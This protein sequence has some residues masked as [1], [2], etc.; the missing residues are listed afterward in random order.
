MAGNEPKVRVRMYRQGLGDC[1]LLTFRTGA[2]P[3]HMLV[4]CGTLGATT[5][6]V[7]MGDV[8]TNIAKETGEHLHLLIATHEHKDHVSGFRS[9]SKKFD[10]F[11]IDH[12]WAAW[13]ENP[14]DPLAQ[15][16]KVFGKDLESSLCL[17]SEVLRRSR[18]PVDEELRCIGSGVR[19]LLGFRG[20]LPGDE[21]ML[22]ADFA[23]TVQEAMNYVTKR[24]EGPDWFLSPGRVIEPPW[25]PGV[26]FYVLGP[27]RSKESLLKL[28]D[29]DSPELYHLA[30]Q[31]KRDMDR[32]LR[33][34]ASDQPLP[35]YRPTLDVPAREE[36]DASLPFDWGFRI[37]QDD[38]GAR[39]RYLAAYDD[40]EADWRRIDHEWLRASADLAL[41][42][43][44]MTNNTSL[45]L[46]IELIG[47]GRVLL[48]PADAQLGNWLSW[49][50]LT[51]SVTEADGTTRT[52]TTGDLLKRTVF[53]KVGHH[54]S[55][56]ATL[57]ENGLEAMVS[58]DLVAM[59]PVDSSVASKRNPPWLMPAE[60][61][62]KRLI[63][64]T[65]GRV[66][67]SDTAWPQNDALPPTFSTAELDA[68]RQYPNIVVNDL[69]IDYLLH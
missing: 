63:E 2:A 67:R 18:V 40:P 7:R 60:A 5:T 26:R 37:E 12:T 9:Q 62:Y 19:E 34:A 32:T 11:T 13:T 8:V 68:A 10:E 53:Y 61:L 65:H 29:H 66:L 1:F 47:D 35:E 22:G 27:P 54:A 56:N 45:A 14:D 42:L 43:D 38:A 48:L 36:F 25:L 21:V 4:D 50:D 15:E 31:A 64:K 41:Q 30:V 23:E 28:G 16:V 69:Y 17:A 33:F 24:V 58:D 51:F 44:D 52:V 3:V 57:R 49:K 39:A 55:H 46:A 6:G 59:I 20:D